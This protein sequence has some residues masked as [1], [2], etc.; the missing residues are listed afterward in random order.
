MHNINAV[1]YSIRNNVAYWIILLTTLLFFLRQ[2]I[3]STNTALLVPLRYLRQHYVTYV[4][5]R[6]PE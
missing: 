3:C 2:L 5:D 1:S 6:Q 4:S